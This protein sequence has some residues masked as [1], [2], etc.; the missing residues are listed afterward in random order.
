MS[1]TVQRIVLLALGLLFLF[2][3]A[4]G[5]RMAILEAQYKRFGDELPFTLESALH[6]RRVKMVY[7]TGRIQ[8]HDAMVQ[9]PEGIDP[10]TTYTLGAE[11]FYAALAKYFP[12]HIPVPTRVRI[13]EAGWFSLG[14]SFLALGLYGWRRNL[15]A[16]VWGSLFYAISLSSVI[17]STG[18]ELSHENFALPFL[19]G[20]WALLV[21]SPEVRSRWLRVGFNL[22]QRC[23]WG[24]LFVHGIWFSFTSRSA[25]SFGYG[26]RCALRFAHR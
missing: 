9:F 11:Y 22:S 20:H 16:A 17:R 4:M 13:L 26:A 14:I 2:T 10:R 19:I 1:S 12:S 23:F 21:W 15:G 25:F 3:L 7:D 18:Q 5:A 6:Y 24:G 8:A